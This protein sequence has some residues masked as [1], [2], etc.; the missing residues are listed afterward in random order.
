MEAEA[1]QLTAHLFERDRRWLH[2]QP[3]LL[4]LMEAL[5][6]AAGLRVMGPRVLITSARDG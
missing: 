4:G 6:L 3:A 2:C 5:D 1:I